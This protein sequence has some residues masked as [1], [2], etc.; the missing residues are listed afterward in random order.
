MRRRRLPPEEMHNKERWLI[1]YA[2]FITLLFGFFVVMYAISSVNEGKYERL[3]RS[4]EGVFRVAPRS[5]E[6]IAI[7]EHPPVGRPIP[8]VGSGGLPELDRL[9][10][11]FATVFD[12]MLEQGVVS[13]EREGRWLQLTLPD[14]LLFAPGEAEPHFD[15]FDVVESI[16]RVL[17]GS[18]NALLVEGFTDN[19][20]IRSDRYPSNWELSAA[21]AATLVRMLEAEGIASGRMAAVGYGQHQPRTDN[22]TAAG[23]RANRRVVLL[24]SAS[25]DVRDLQ[26]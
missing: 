24:V 4:L 11:E 22:D 5:L 1:S 20:P 7:G 8:Q 9:E 17:R 2:D 19:R 15:A 13:V 26:R 3:S 6:P 10:G 18:D 25:S 23:R 21:R 16:A 14:S 12:E